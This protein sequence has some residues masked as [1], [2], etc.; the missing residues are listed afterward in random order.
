MTTLTILG[1]Y[2]ALDCPACGFQF[3][4]PETF[5]DR[6]RKDGRNAYC[7]ACRGAMCWGESEAD[8][9]RT[10]LENANRRTEMVE[11][12]LTHERDQREAAERSAR[13]Q[14]AA[15]TRLRKRV[16]NGVCPCC[17]RT[18]ADL[19][20]HMEGQHPDFATAGDAL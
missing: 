10:Y 18:F 3:A 15:N 5:V 17:R 4:L 6:R 1:T 14:R 11:A 8:K 2:Q 19:A 9:L 16:S 13:A 12:Q 20:R 7:P